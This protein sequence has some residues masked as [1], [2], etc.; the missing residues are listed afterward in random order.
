MGT[1]VPEPVY[2]MEQELHLDC[3]IIGAGISG[4]DAAYHLNTYSSWANYLILERRSNLGGTW[5]FFKYPGIRSDSDMYTF[6]FSW[7]I[8]KSPKPIAPGEDILEYLTEAANEQGIM[9]KI[10]FNT[11]E[12]QKDRSCILLLYTF[13]QLFLN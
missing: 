9:N 4:I 7:K 10:K 13:F 11:Y 6:G 1:D 12:Y 2:I 3:I 5:D 8:W